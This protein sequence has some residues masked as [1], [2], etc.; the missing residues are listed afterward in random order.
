MAKIISIGLHHIFL[1]TL[2]EIYLDERFF[3]VVIVDD[4][5]ILRLRFDNFLFFE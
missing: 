2:S 5:A 1:I 4:D 3:S